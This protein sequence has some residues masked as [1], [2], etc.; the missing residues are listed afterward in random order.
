MISSGIPIYSVFLFTD[1][2]LGDP[3]QVVFGANIAGED[4]IGEA[5]KPAL[6]SRLPDRNARADLPLDQR[7]PNLQRLGADIAGCD[8]AFGNDERRPYRKLPDDT[9][10]GIGD[11]CGDL[12]LSVFVRCREIQA[13]PAGED[14]N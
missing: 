7:L 9:G 4:H 2:R 12:Q 14:G 1:Q 11:L 8:A 3:L 5:G 13:L 6:L 10:Q